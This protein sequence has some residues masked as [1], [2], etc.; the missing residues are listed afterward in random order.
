MDRRE[1]RESN[2]GEEWGE[3][4][5]FMWQDL[6]EAQSSVRCAEGSLQVRAPPHLSVSRSPTNILSQWGYIHSIDF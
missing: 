1:E 6:K 4:P 5:S 3:I 2:S